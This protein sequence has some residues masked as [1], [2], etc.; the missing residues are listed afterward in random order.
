MKLA[1][2][3]AA[4]SASIALVAGCGRA[5]VT[6][7]PTPTQTATATATATPQV[8][9]VAATLEDLAARA[10]AHTSYVN[11]VP[12]FLVIA[13]TA[14]GETVAICEYGAG[15]GEVVVINSAHDAEDECSRRYSPSRVVDVVVLP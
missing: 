7:A 8:T 15:A 6:T 1:Q 9:R 12:S 3:V 13:P 11:C 5:P 14:P 4:T 10:C 2:V